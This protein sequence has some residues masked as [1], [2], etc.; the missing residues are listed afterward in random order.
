MLLNTRTTLTKYNSMYAQLKIYSP[1]LGWDTA[2][3]LTK[4]DLPADIWTQIQ[5]GKKFKAD[6]LVMFGFREE[7]C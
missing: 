6:N 5:N 4:N 3:Y 2:K 7:Q 1:D